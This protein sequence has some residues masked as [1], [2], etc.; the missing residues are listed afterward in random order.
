M[1]TACDEPD[2]LHVNKSPLWSYLAKHVQQHLSQQD[3]QR[4]REE[5]G[6]ALIRSLATE[7]D[8]EVNRVI[9]SWLRTVRLKKAGVDRLLDTPDPDGE[10]ASL[11]EWRRRLT[12]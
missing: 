6:E 9:E 4:M 12:V 11:A 3:Q 7:S 1:T 10:G 8:D 2:V 5:M